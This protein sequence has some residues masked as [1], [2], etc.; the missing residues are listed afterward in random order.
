MDEWKSAGD[1]YLRNKQCS[2]LHTCEYYRE[3]GSNPGELRSWLIEAG[4]VC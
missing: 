2:N 1:L 3:F 4:A